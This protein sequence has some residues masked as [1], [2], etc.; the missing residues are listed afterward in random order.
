MG[1]PVFHFKSSRQPLLWAAVAHSLGIT[2]GVYAWRPALWWVLAATAFVAAAAYFAPRRAWLGWTL[3]LTAFFLTGALHVQVRSASPH[4]DTRI[5]PYADGQDLQITAHVTR[6]GRLQ[7]SGFNE[8]RQ[9]VDV[10]TEE[11]TTTSGETAAVHSG[12]RLSI[13]SP[14][15]SDATP[16]EIPAGN[17][18]AAFT[19]T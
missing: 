10:E 18:T 11:L 19:G 6:D 7:Q 9:S 2:A 17:S 5:Q 13:Y 1:P 14:R 4:L 3:A 15:P 12:I 16:E 8:T